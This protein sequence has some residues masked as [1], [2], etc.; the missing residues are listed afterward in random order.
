[1]EELDI[2]ELLYALKKRIKYIVIAVVICAL[3]GFIYSKFLVTPMYKSSTTFVLSK[4]TENNVQV[5]NTS[6]E[7]ITQS[8]ITLNSK[9]VSTYSEIIKSKTIAKEV[10]N[11]LGLDMTVEQFKSNVT[12][13]SKDDTEL[14]EITVSNENGKIAAD[15]A[16]SLAEVFREKVYEVYKIDNLSIIDV[17]EEN[18]EPYNI[19]TVKNIVLFALV[20]MVLSCGIIFLIVYFDDTIKDEKD[21][22]ALLNI[23]VIASIPK[24]E[25]NDEGG[26][27]K[28][29]KV[30]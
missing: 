2:I 28:W 5:E 21:I 30:K 18:T 13:T 11:T 19:G 1:M 15:I 14:I 25:D 29:K 22:E 20:G 4:S 10:I 9:L 8:D 23:P 16:N 6:S 24:L 26:F 17:A 12:V 3:V 27:F 7:A